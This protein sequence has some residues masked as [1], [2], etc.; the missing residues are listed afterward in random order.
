MRAV[1]GLIFTMNEHCDPGSDRVKQRV[2][3][4][5]REAVKPPGG[6]E[7]DRAAAMRCFLIIL[8][9]LERWQTWKH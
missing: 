1:I 4:V 3:E 6:S 8:R 7:A 2:S 9:E 5:E